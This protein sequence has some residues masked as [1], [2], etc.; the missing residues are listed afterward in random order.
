MRFKTKT[1]VLTLL[2]IAYTYASPSIIAQSTDAESPT[3]V[4]TN[5]LMIAGP[6]KNNQQFYY[7]FSAGPGEVT[8]T[9]HVKAKSSSTFVGVKVFDSEMNTVTYHNMS[10]DTI[11]PGLAKKKFDV[12]DKQTLIMSFTS[13]GNLAN[14]KITFGGAVE[15]GGPMAGSV[16]NGELV[17]ET[18]PPVTTDTGALSTEP[19]STLSYQG[20]TMSNNKSFTLN[21]LDAVGQRFNI[22]VNGKLRIE[23]KDGTVQE[24]DLAQVKKIQVKK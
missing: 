15:F 1:C 24:I 5:E 10:A 22:P 13:D 4:E 6:K 20:Q 3:P 7:S 2:L 12:G 23:M 11:S 8:M 19:Q 16:P 9:F 21:I 18:V 14:C 17:S